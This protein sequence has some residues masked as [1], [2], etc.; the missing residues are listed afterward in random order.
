MHRIKFFYHLLK[1]RSN[2]PQKEVFRKGA[3]VKREHHNLYRFFVPIVTKLNRESVFESK[4]HNLSSS[5]QNL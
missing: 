5:N 1:I 3:Q 4:L 2:V